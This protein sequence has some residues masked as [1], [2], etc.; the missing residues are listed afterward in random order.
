MVVSELPGKKRSRPFLLGVTVDAEVQAIFRAMCVSGAVVNTSIAIATAMSVIRKQD[1]SLLKEEGSPLELTKNWAKSILYRMGFVERSD[2]T[3]SKVGVEQSEALKTQYLFN[4]KA[5]V[6]IMEIPP[7]L[8]INWDQ[9]GIKIIPV[10]SWMMEKRGGKR[11]EIAGV[12]NKHQIT[13]VFTATA[14]SEF[15]PIQLIY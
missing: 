9:A 10:S 6:E 1:K 13:A 2:N 4:I 11:V 14:V 12:N 8:V 3:K 5:T 15:L 7:E